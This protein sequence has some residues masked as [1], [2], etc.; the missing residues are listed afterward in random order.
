MYDE[1]N[2]YSYNSTNGRNSAGSSYGRSRYTVANIYANYQYTLLEK[3]RFDLMAG[4]S[5][6]EEDHRTFNAYRRLGLISPE[7]PTFGV[8]SS[9]EQ[10]NGE[11]KSDRALNSV[12]PGW[13]IRST[14]NIYWKEPSVTMA[15]PALPKGID[16]HLSLAFPVPGRYRMSPLCNRS[17]IL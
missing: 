13:D 4:Y 2:K 15:L 9:D 14:I 17:I 16:G 8:G 5:H 11:T 7:L 10:Y 12:L 3:N 6:E 1:N